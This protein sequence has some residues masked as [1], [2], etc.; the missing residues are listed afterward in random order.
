MKK[1]GSIRKVATH[2]SDLHSTI[3]NRCVHS[4]TRRTVLYGKVVVTR[5]AVKY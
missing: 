2:L 3:A 5:G 1:L 4:D